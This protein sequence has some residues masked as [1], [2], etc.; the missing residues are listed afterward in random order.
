[1]QTFCPSLWDTGKDHFCSSTL[2]SVCFVWLKPYLYFKNESRLSHADMNMIIEIYN[3]QLLINQLTINSKGWLQNSEPV[4]GVQVRD[5]NP[6]VG[7]LARELNSRGWL[8]VYC[9]TFH[10]T[11]NI[12]LLNNLGS[13]QQILRSPRD[14]TCSVC[15][16]VRLCFS[17]FSCFVNS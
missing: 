2:W 5:L 1:M 14:K 9:I 11:K 3:H 12:W 15:V 4:S 6:R 10:L 13:L 8:T 16:L 7:P 17:S